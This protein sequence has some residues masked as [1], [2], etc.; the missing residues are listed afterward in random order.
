VGSG[1]PESDAA[2]LELQRRIHGVMG[3]LSS[4]LREVLVLTEID[5]LRPQEAAEVLGI[6]VNTVRSRRRLAAEEFKRLWRHT[7]QEHEK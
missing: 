4:K 5:G 3:D 6:P 7:H 1:D 2:G